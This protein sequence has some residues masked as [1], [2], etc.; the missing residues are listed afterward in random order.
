M[1]RRSGKAVVRKGT[2]P[3][4]SKKNP[5]DGGRKLVGQA[6]GQRAMKDPL[7]VSGVSGVSEVK[8]C[9]EE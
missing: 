7:H 9:L 5:G 1:K 6:F 8:S 4:R 2:L 3:K